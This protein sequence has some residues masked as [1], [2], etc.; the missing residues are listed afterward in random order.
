MVS[1]PAVAGKSKRHFLPCQEREIKMPFSQKVFDARQKQ[2]WRDESARA[3]AKRQ[4]GESSH[5]TLGRL[6]GWGGGGGSAADTMSTNAHEREGG[7]R[8]GRLAIHML[9]QMSRWQEDR[10]HTA[11]GCGGPSVGVRGSG[12]RG[13]LGAG[14]GKENLGRQEGRLGKGN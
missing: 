9:P 2:K 1:L 3:R 10:P 13:L 6:G 11:W 5:T 7:G 4:K 14:K 12:G 8:H